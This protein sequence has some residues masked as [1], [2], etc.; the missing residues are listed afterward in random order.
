MEK[1]NNKLKRAAYYLV[2]YIYIYIYTLI[3][4]LFRILVLFSSSFSRKNEVE[5][6]IPL[7]HLACGQ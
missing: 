6:D 2:I 7:D 5:E 4:F 1:Y 3:L